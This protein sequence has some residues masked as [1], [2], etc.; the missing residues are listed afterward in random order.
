MTLLSS[1]RRAGG[2]SRFALLARSVA[3][4]ALAAGSAYGALFLETGARA[5]AAFQEAERYRRWAHDP[6]AKVRE[7]EKDY[8]KA[9]ERLA[10]LR[11]RGDRSADELRLE[12]DILQARFDLRRAESPAQRA[13]F[14][15][16]DVYRLYSPPPTELSRRAR[17]L[18]PAAK[19]AWRE[20]VSRAGV[21]P[22]EEL[23]GPE[24]CE[25]ADR[26]AVYSTTDKF[27]ASNLV[28]ILKT[29]GVPAEVLEG[30]DA[31]PG[32]WITVPSADFWRAHRKLVSLLAPDLAPVFVK[33]GQ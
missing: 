17:L 8:L 12:Q 13:Y 28:A 6:V 33:W 15:Y 11:A 7:L 10:A 21:S 5:R 31:D 14:L 27:D 9:N 16:R 23:I 4:L 1:L 3:G 2:L 26:R 25:K 29:N 24:F 19:Q 18:A 30:K 22:S 20:D 32:Y